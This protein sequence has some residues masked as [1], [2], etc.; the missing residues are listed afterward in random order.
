MVGG[1]AETVA[2]GCGRR[3]GGRRRRHGTTAP[4]PGFG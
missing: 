1:A 4:T 2:P 3:R